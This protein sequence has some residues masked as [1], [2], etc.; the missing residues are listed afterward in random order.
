MLSSC[1]SP[2]SVCASGEHQQIYQNWIV[3]YPH[4]NRTFTNPYEKH[5]Q[6][7]PEWNLKLV[8]AISNLHWSTAYHKSLLFIFPLWYLTACYE[9]E[10]THFVTNP[11][12]A[13]CTPVR[14]S[15]TFIQTVHAPLFKKNSE[16]WHSSCSG[17]GT[18]TGLPVDFITCSRMEAFWIQISSKVSK[19]KNT[20]DRSNS[21]NLALPQII[22]NWRGPCPV[23]APGFFACLEARSPSSPNASSHERLPQLCCHDRS[24]YTV[25]GLPVV[26]STKKN[27]SEEG[28]LNKLVYIRVICIIG[29]RVFTLDSDSWPWGFQC[30]ILASDY[31]CEFSS[32]GIRSS[33]NGCFQKFYN[34]PLQPHIFNLHIKGFH[35]TIPAPE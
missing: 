20:C 35:F 25:G 30:L 5:V 9:K 21:L 34:S 6:K 31:T 4:I 11:K 2:S 8:P 19:L 13:R 26:D 7:I 1:F 10:N 29:Y 24:C 28:Q 15:K 23:T 18:P 14:V 3:G 32:H 22:E 17:G 27:K 33:Q 16:M 12:W